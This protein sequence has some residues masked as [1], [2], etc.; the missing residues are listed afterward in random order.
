M[1]TN[2]FREE[3]IADSKVEGY[4]N[5]LQDYSMSSKSV[6]IISKS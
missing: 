2:V 6:P 5:K 3:A 4:K 1:R